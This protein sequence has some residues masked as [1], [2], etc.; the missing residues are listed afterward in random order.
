[1]QYFYTQKEY[2]EYQ[3]KRNLRSTS[4]GIGLLMILFMIAELVFSIV[5]VFASF[6]SGDSLTDAMDTAFGMTLINGLFSLIT[7]FF[8][9]IIF[10]LFRREPLAELFPFQKIGAGY[11]VMLVVIGVAFSLLSNY[12]ADAVSRMFEMFGLTSSYSGGV[13]IEGTGDI[14]MSYLTIAVIPALAEEFAFRGIVMG[15]LKKYS[16]ALAVI[17]SSAIFGLMHGNIIQIPFAF[18]GGLIFGFIA[19]KTNSLLPG[20]LIHFFNNGISVTL[21][22]LQTNTPLTENTVNIIFVI[23]MIVLCILSFIFIR[24]IIKTKKD[25][26]SFP[27]SNKGISFREKMKTVCSS[28][29]LIVYTV[30][31]II[32]TVIVEM[33]Q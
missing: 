26:F 2:E 13:E 33:T 25:F 11:L 22:I 14:F 32:Y 9:G 21:D 1:M 17:V 28:P 18:C 20:I 15:M 10:C 23:L 4:N 3:Y 8:V 27:D 19:L 31:I 12:A 24:K 29:T 7:F 6:L 30:M 5:F 16:G